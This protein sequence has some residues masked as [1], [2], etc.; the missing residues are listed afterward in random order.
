MPDQHDVIGLQIIRLALDHIADRALDK[1]RNLIKIMIVVGDLLSFPVCQMKQPELTV[2]V[3]F[4]CI[5]FHKN[6][7]WGQGVM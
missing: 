7:H 1:N 5:Y 6:L 3:A 2:E 4:F